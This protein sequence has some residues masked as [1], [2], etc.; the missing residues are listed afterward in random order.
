MKKNKKILISTLVMLLVITG[1]SSMV[2]TADKHTQWPSWP[3]SV[4]A[5][6]GGTAI[7][8]MDDIENNDFPSFDF[9]VR[10]NT[11]KGT[12][13]VYINKLSRNYDSWWSD[14]G[15]NFGLN[16]MDPFELHDHTCSVHPTSPGEY[17]N[18]LYAIGVVVIVEWDPVQIRWTID[19]WGVYDDVEYLVIVLEDENDPI[20]T[21][22]A[23]DPEPE[24]W[25][26]EE[27]ADSLS[28]EQ[29]REM[30]EATGA[31]IEGITNEPYSDI[32]PTSSP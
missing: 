13:F 16:I 15:Y 30:N 23:S 29:I 18:T 22:R 9:W 10:H 20:P 14:G 1:F 17:T 31:Y 7:I 3:P 19:A 4:A 5:Y 8:T 11:Y 25:S 2:I 26:L 6:G 32:L 21:S 12:A 27:V 28:A 24:I